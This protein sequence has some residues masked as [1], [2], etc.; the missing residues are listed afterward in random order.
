MCLLVYDQN[1]YQGWGVGQGSWKV[2]EEKMFEVRWWRKGV[3]IKTSFIKQFQGG[4]GKDYVYGGR[5]S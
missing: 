1:F 2:G 5:E 4:K 3:I